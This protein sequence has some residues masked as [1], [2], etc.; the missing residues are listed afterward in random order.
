MNRESPGT[1]CQHR[2]LPKRK[3][4]E[5]CSPILVLGLVLSSTRATAKTPFLLSCI[6]GRSSTRSYTKR[7]QNIQIVCLVTRGC[8]KYV[9]WVVTAYTPMHNI[10]QRHHC[11][12]LW[13]MKWC[14]YKLCCPVVKTVIIG[15]VW[16]IHAWSKFNLQLI[17]A[18]PNLTWE[19]FPSLLQLSATN[20]FLHTRI[21]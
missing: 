6:Q 15:W 9:K 18:I 12:H 10:P 21:D 2:N 17:L 8:G 1:L 16:L 7:L 3:T 14:D 19:S 11:A 13:R 5:K 4:Q 20:S